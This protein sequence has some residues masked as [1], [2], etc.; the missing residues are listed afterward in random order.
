MRL[1]KK[2]FYI[3]TYNKLLFI[4]TN[5]QLDPDPSTLEQYLKGV[6]HCLTLGQEH[7]ARHSC[8]PESEG[9]V[10]NLKLALNFLIQAHEVIATE[11]NSGCAWKS[12][13]VLFIKMN[14][15]ILSW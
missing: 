15:I 11:L 6:S 10:V 2:T 13:E 3:L 4:V 8:C 12:S 9:D 7:E 14:L 5:H 1:D